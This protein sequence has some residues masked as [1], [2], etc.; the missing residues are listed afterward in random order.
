MTILF[1]GG[2][3]SASTIANLRALA[4]DLERMTMFQP[5]GELEEAPSLNGWSP[6]MR[7]VGGLS[8][9][10]EG[11]PLLGCRHVVT[12]EV[13]AIDAERGWARTFSRFYRLGDAAAPTK[14][15]SQ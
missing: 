14:D 6:V 10:V 15:L 7:P 13:F 1:P 3:D 12:S 4:D 11:H 5:N 9:Y 8:G 2:G